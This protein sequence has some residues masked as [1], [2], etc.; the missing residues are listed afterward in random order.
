MDNDTNSQ[1]SVGG[2]EPEGTQPGS[3]GKTRRL[4]LKMAGVGGV[5]GAAGAAGVAGIAAAS[6]EPTSSAQP[7]PTLA[8]P[9][10]GVASILGV[11]DAGAALAFF[12]SAFDATVLLAAKNPA[13]DIV[14]AEFVIDGT[15]LGVTNEDPNFGIV[16][17][18]PGATPNCEA[19]I[20][21]DIQSSIDR[22]AANGGTVLMETVEVADF[23][24]HACF[25]DPFGHNWHLFQVLR[26]FTAAELQ[27]AIEQD[28]TEE[29][30]SY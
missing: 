1:A 30:H 6:G 15:V 24:L 18:T 8:Y 7:Q 23:M 12:T 16:A 28:L 20:V 10:K 25:R 26:P 29:S 22:V 9:T 3:D 2:T 14:H 17:P 27:R 5:L 21:Q 19:V 13:G 11:T 4:V